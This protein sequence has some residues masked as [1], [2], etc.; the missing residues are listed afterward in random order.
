MYTNNCFILE[1][2]RLWHGDASP[3]MEG[4]EMAGERVGASIALDRV[5]CCYA[6][7]GGSENG[8]ICA[9]LTYARGSIQRAVDDGYIS[10]LC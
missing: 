10:V 9:R 7:G 1:A 2:G 4:Y 8:E 6:K 5:V 3:K